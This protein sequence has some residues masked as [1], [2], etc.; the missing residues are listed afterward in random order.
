MPVHITVKDTRTMD[1]TI[2]QQV[3]LDEAFVPHV[4]RLR[5]GK[6]SFRLRSDITSKEST[7]QLLNS[8][9]SIRFKMDNKKRIVNLE[10]FREMLHICP[11]LPGKTFDELS[12]KE[13]ILAFL[14]FLGYSGEIRK[15]TDVNINKLHQPWRSF[16]AVINKCLSG[17][18]TG[19]APPKTKASVRKTKSSF[20]TSITPPTATG[21]RLLTS[22]KGKQ[23][24][25]ASK[26]KGLTVLSEVAMTEAEQINLAMKRAYS[27][28]I[29]PKLVVL[30]SDEDDDDEVDERSDDR[31][32]DDDDDQDDDDQ[33]EGNDDD[34]D[35]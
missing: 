22:A 6:S 1:M 29:S 3:P 32:D 20:D 19:A 28:L 4:S 30:S 31:D 7:L 2:D 25:K 8:G 24:A 23:V 21:T 27:K 9:H 10:Y 17:K 35:T 11:R 26:A 16:A 15:L 34:Q 5:I 12:F 14:I 33:D 13:E 18:S